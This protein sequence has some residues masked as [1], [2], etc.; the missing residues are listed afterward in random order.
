MSK[1]FASLAWP[2]IKTLIN[3]LCLYHR[4]LLLPFPL[5][6]TMDN[7]SPIKH[8]CIDCYHRHARVAHHYLETNVV[9][10]VKIVQVMNCSAALRDPL[11]ENHPKI[12][13]N[14]SI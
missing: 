14:V 8:F 13:Q 2:C 3:D 6:P 10:K 12:T 11:F 1:I 9:N 4:A 7:N 5:F